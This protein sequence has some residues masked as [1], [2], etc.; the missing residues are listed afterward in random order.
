MMAA[1]GDHCSR[2]ELEN[3]ELLQHPRVQRFIWIA[4]GHRNGIRSL[5]RQIVLGIPDGLSNRTGTSPSL[6]FCP[7]GDL[8]DTGKGARER[9]DAAYRDWCEKN[10]MGNITSDREWLVSV[11]EAFLCPLL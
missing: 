1:V 3:L 9:L 8:T 10:I 4:G 6:Y 5:D 2:R 11:T 7:D